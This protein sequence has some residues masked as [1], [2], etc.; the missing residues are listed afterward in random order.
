[1]S[2]PKYNLGPEGGELVP[3][4]RETPIKV[5]KCGPRLIKPIDSLYVA[6]QNLRYCAT[7]LSM[8][9]AYKFAR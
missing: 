4:L 8:R 2:K 6:T 1:M 9:E 3:Q 5:F 7:H